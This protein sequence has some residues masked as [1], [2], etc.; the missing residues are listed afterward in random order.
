[1]GHGRRN[2]LAPLPSFERFFALNMY[3][4]GCCL[5]RVEAKVRGRRKT[6]GERMKQD[7]AALLPLSAVPYDA[8]DKRMARVSSLSLVRYKILLAIC[9]RMKNSSDTMIKHIDRTFFDGPILLLFT[10][11]S[12]TELTQENLRGQGS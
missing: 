1:M 12:E 6:I 2:F 10:P 4:E 8:S 11:V 7:L 3:L 9:A 5:K